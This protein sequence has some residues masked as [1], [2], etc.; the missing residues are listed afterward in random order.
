MFSY[1]RKMVLHV[2]F[3]LHWIKTKQLGHPL[4]LLFPY[5]SG[6]MIQTEIQVE[7]SHAD[8]T[9]SKYF[10]MTLRIS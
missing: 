3:Y 1:L 7:I 9:F 6:L 5:F 4:N 8:I 10:P 2:N